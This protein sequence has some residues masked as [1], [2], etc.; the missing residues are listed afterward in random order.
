L[1][2]IIPD[3]KAYTLFSRNFNVEELGAFM[4][5]LASTNDVLAKGKLT[6]GG[7]WASFEPLGSIRYS[8]SLPNTEECVKKQKGLSAISVK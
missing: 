5:L 2:T 3:S 8:G 1:R 4:A 6:E 7:L